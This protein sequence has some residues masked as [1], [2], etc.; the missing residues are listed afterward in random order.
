M[1]RNSGRN[2]SDGGFMIN[3]EEYYESGAYLDGEEVPTYYQSDA[4]NML[5][6]GVIT[7]EEY[8]QANIIPD[9]V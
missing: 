4:D 1:R 5:R 6:E 8:R 2:G 9:V 3:R 7:E